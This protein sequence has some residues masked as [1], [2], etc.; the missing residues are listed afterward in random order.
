PFVM[1]GRLKSALGNANE[2]G[3]SQVNE[4]RVGFRVPQADRCMKRGLA[5]RYLRL[6]LEGARTLDRPGTGEQTARRTQMPTRI[7]PDFEIARVARRR[8]QVDLQRIQEES[9]RGNPTPDH[10]LLKLAKQ[11]IRIRHGTETRV[12]VRESST[13]SNNRS[14]RGERRMG[15]LFT[16]AFVRDRAHRDPGI[17]PRARRGVEPASAICAVERCESRYGRT[18]MARRESDG[19]SIRPPRQSRRRA[20]GSS[21]RRRPIVGIG[22]RADRV[23]R[24]RT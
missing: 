20:T 16:S 11:W 24:P 22:G 7:A 5:A 9:G 6:V 8:L 21:H 12:V 18:D 3:P 15:P 17:E 4:S 10:E 13:A 19:Q 14:K 1:W 23:Q 2:H